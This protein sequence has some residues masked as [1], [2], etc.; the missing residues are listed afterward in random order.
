ME[1]LSHDYESMLPQFED[2]KRALVKAQ[3]E[4]L[5]MKQRFQDLEVKH[6]QLVHQDSCETIDKSM[7][8]AKV[9]EI[10]K[11][12]ERFNEIMANVK[13]KEAKI[14]NLHQKLNDSEEALRTAEN[15]RGSYKKQV[16]GFNF[17]L[18][19]LQVEQSELKGDRTLSYFI[20]HSFVIIL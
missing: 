5:N 4:M 9:N 14:Q 13:E 2:N 1:R 11:L 20:M 16:D 19:G 10:G 7:Y 3:N 17:Q 8:D 18:H 6:G 15:E 12:Q